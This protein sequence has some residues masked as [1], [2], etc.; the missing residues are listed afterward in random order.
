MEFENQY[1]TYDEYLDFDE[2]EIGEMPFNL[3]EF[4]VRKKIDTRTQNRLHDLENIPIEVKMCAYKC[5]ETLQKYNSV[6]KNISSES[7][8]G[9]S[10]SYNNSNYSKTFE[11]DIEDIICNYL[12]NV[13]VNGVPVL[14][15]G[16]C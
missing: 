15:L 4:D 6:D 10:V 1:L 11:E 13:V 3:L 8:D 12:S 5:I 9:Y 2:N 14:Y 7:T 16:V